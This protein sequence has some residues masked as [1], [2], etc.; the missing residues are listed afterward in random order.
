M[1]CLY[2]YVAVPTDKNV[3]RLLSEAERFMVRTLEIYS[4]RCSGLMVLRT[5]RVHI[6]YYYG[7]SP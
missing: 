7:I 3:R 1:E 2:Y 6:H 5:Q 4:S